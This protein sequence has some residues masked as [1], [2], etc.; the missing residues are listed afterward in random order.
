LHQAVALEH[1]AAHD[2]QDAAAVVIAAEMPMVLL[3]NG[4]LNRFTMRRD[5]DVMRLEKK[6]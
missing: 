6:P 3:G 2:A 5:S 1:D 4:F